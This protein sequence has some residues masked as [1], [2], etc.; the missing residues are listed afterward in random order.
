MPYANDVET[1]NQ[2]IFSRSDFSVA[3]NC[4]G[5]VEHPT[6]EHKLKDVATFLGGD[7]SRESKTV[8]AVET[9]SSP[10]YLDHDF[11]TWNIVPYI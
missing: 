2:M 3:S 6:K 7:L 11:G 8:D 9:P 1:R 10:G 5:A 4:L